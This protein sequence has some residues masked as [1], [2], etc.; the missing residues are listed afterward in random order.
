VR[1][2][3]SSAR[4][5]DEGTANLRPLERMAMNY[6][7]RLPLAPAE[8]RHGFLRSCCSG[9][10]LLETPEASEI[11][12]RI[13]LPSVLLQGHRPVRF[14]NRFWQS[15][16]L[17][18]G[19]VHPPGW[20]MSGR[21]QTEVSKAR[22]GRHRWRHVRPLC[23]ALR[24]WRCPWSQA[25]RPTR[26]W[27]VGDLAGVS[28]ERTS[29]GADHLAHARVP[30]LGHSTIYFQ[31]TRDQTSGAQLAVERFESCFRPTS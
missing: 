22:D 25:R 17:L 11:R 12:R 18:L 31:T 24:R 29:G 28:L 21:G 20:G 26:G 5:R 13:G 19:R 14:F 15:I 8:S 4:S 3:D 10:S 9:R 23:R 2:G 27:I 1:C 7:N 30:F 16:R 6:H